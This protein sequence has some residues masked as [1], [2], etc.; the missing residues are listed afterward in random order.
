MA[1]GSI[2][3]EPFEDGLYSIQIEGDF[4]AAMQE[5]GIAV[6]DA[7]LNDD[8]RA[9]LIDV[10]RC[11]F[12]DSTAI[13]VILGAR[14]RAL[15]AGIGFALVGHNPTIDRTIELTGLGEDLEILTDSEEAIGLL[16]LD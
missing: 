4:D 5:K 16:A 2:R 7:A 13:A 6:T 3:G 10:K 14:Q 15:D 11:T 12:L 1:N 9:I 8:T